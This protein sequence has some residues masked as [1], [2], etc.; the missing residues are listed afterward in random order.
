MNNTFMTLTPQAGGGYSG[1]E[2]IGE[3]TELQRRCDSSYGNID[4]AEVQMHLIHSRDTLLPEMAPNLGKSAEKV[5]RRRG[6]LAGGVISAA[7]GGQHQ[8]R[9]RHCGPSHH[10]GTSHRWSSMEVLRR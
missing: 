1:V 6:V 4:H 7:A 8:P 9:H 10:R 2:T 5:L 3:N